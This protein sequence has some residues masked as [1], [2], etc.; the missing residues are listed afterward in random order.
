MKRA[1][2]RFLEYVKVYTTSDDGNRGGHPSSAR[3][4]DLARML[5]EEMKEIGIAD[6]RVDEHCYVFGSVPATAG[7]EDAPAIGF[8]AHMDTA[9]DAEGENVRPMLY[10][11]YNGGD[12][13]LANGLVTDAATFPDI[14]RLAGKTLITSSGDTLLGADDKAGIAEI[15]AMCER[16]LAEGRPHGKICVGFTPDEEIGAGADCFDV[17]AFGADYA[18]TVDGGPVGDIEYETFNAARAAAVFTGVEVHPGSAKDIMVNALDLAMEFDALLPKDERPQNTEGREGYYFLHSLSGAVGKAEAR[19]YVRE[20]DEG[21]FAARKE[22]LQKA[23]GAVC[24]KYG[25]GSAVVEIEDEYRNMAG[26]IEANMHLVE[27]ARTA[28]RKAGLAPETK[29]VRGGTDGS[30]LSFM[31]LP[32]PNLGTG[33]LYFHGPHECIAAEDMDK[34]VEV[35]LGI[36]E[37]YAGSGK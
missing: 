37:V 6:A 32:C 24:A 15:M 25:E 4:F 36:V 3:Q 30:A 11:N 7:C 21:K 2:E 28:I 22:A 19:Y 26:V 20:H 31:G 35:L 23:A 12:V 18:Y 9:P 5:V 27:N 33:G 14:K 17:A 29:P 16:L 10:P 1:S 8:L 13:K 34:A